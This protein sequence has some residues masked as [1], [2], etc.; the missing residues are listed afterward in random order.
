MVVSVGLL[1]FHLYGLLIGLG[2]LM[3]AVVASKIAKVKL[4]NVFEA[5]IWSVGFG[6]VGARLY[7]VIDFWSYYSVNLNEI[8]MVW[9]GG[10]GIFGGILGGV[11]GGWLQR[12]GYELKLRKVRNLRKGATLPFLKML[13]V[14]GLGLSIGQAIGRWGNFF[15]QEL[16]GKPTD[17]PWGIYIKPENRL[18]EVIEF[19]RFHPLFL[20]ESVLCLGIFLILWWLVRSKKVKVG[21]GKLFVYYLGLY[22][23]VRFFLE[24]LRID[25]WMINGVNV[26]QVISAGLVAIAIITLLERDF[27]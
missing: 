5:M 27:K 9:K 17:L 11:I 26:A 22:G 8:V 20:Y 21:G 19:E 3:G 18:I 1:N 10:M 15:N 12:V 16:Y 2:I 24:F 6:L 23:L 25:P 4:D 13:D 7:H 14:G